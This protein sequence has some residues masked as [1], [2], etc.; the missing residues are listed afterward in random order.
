MSIRP[1]PITCEAFSHV[2][3][4]KNRKKLMMLGN[5]SPPNGKNSPYSPINLL[6]TNSTINIELNGSKPSIA[7]YINSNQKEKKRS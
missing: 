2:R 1:L 7:H 4:E 5:I 6:K 3:R